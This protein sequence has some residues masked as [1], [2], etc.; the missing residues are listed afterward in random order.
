VARMV[1][2]FA[3]SR[4]ITQCKPAYAALSPQYRV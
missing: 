3:A 1:S 4:G 2:E